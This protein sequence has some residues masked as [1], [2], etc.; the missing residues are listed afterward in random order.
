MRTGGAHR[1]ARLLEASWPG[2]PLG[3]RNGAQRRKAQG[4]RRMPCWN[5]FFRLIPM[6]QQ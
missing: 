5:C 4:K 2:D 6:K 1:T 3:H